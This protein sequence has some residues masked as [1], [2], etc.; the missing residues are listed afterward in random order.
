MAGIFVEWND[1][2]SVYLS[3]KMSWHLVRV[4]RGSNAMQ[5]APDRT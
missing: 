3:D 5:R 1:G 2:N 4:T